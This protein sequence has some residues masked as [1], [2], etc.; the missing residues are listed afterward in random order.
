MIK[1]KIDSFFVHDEIYI[2]L[3]EF[4]IKLSKKI[5]IHLM[6]ILYM[7]IYLVHIVKMIIHLIDT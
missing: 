6:N 3:P 2:L 5:I 1:K 7:M 4:L